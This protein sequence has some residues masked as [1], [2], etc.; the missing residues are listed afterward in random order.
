MTEGTLSADPVNSN[1]G[2]P[3]ANKFFNNPDSISAENNSV[4]KEEPVKVEAKV[5]EK[6]EVKAEEKVEEKAPEKYDLKIPENSRLSPKSL[7]RI[8]DYAKKQGLTNEKAQGLV[9]LEAQA[10]AEFESNQAVELDQLR[11]AWVSQVKSDQEIGGDNFNQSIEHAKRAIKQFGT[12]SFIQGLNETGYGDHPEV[13]RLFAR[14]GKLLG[15]DKIVHSNNYS[16]KKMED[17]FYNNKS[18]E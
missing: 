7:E 3:D 15:D 9:E 1:P 2:E 4:K 10:K 8:A 6:V 12:D 13:V 5:E 14:I 17:A 16:G 18:R 11:N